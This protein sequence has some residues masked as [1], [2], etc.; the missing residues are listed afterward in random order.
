M[1]PRLAS[2]M[3]GIVFGDQR[4]GTAQQ[5]HARLAQRFIEGDVGLVGADQIGGLLDDGTIPGQNGV[6]DAFGGIVAGP[7]A[8]GNMGRIRIESNTE[9]ALIA[10]DRGIQL[11]KEVHGVFP[12]SLI[13]EA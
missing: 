12:L 5:L 2:R 7:I 9:Q 10:F 1:S 4:Q 11:L 3:T 6:D 13:V 8:R